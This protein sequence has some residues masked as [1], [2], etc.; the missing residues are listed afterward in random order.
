MSALDANEEQMKAVA[1]ALLQQ[2]IAK[3]NEAKAR[4]QEQIYANEYR[5]TEINNILVMQR[6]KKEARQSRIVRT[7]LVGR[8]CCLNVSH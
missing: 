5:I 6:A 7:R 1:I 4:R 8:S 2:E 3:N